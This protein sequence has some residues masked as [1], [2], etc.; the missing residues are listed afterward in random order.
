MNNNVLFEIVATKDGIKDLAGKI[1][2]KAYGNQPLV[3]SDQHKFGKYSIY[4]PAAGYAIQVTEPKSE[5]LLTPSTKWTFSAW[6]MPTAANG[7]FGYATLMNGNRANRYQRLSIFYENSPTY[8]IYYS[9]SN[10]NLVATHKPI[11]DS[12]IMD[13]NWHHVAF[14]HDDNSTIYTFYDGQLIK[15]E[16]ETENIDWQ[17]TILFTEGAGDNNA[18]SKGYFDDFTFILNECRWTQ[19][20]TPPSVYLG[21]D[22]LIFNN[23]KIGD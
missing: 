5:M 15:T 3:S 1:T 7:S 6:I 10:P 8:N 12:E 20:F 22:P 11:P 23:M 4:L 13:G 2:W 17:N 19:D 14:T 16:Q 9:H 21:S 18:W